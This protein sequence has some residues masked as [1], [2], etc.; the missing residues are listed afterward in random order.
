MRKKKKEIKKRPDRDKKG[1]FLK[2]AR[3]GP[4]RPK[5]QPGDIICK[6]GK[7]RS[8]DALIKDLLLAY[9]AMGGGDFIKKWAL[10][11][12]KNLTKFVE[13]LFRFAPQPEQAGSDIN[14]QVISAVPRQ[15]TDQRV[16]D[17]E[18]RLQESEAEL[19]IYKAQDLK[20]IEHEP[21][22]EDEKDPGIKK[23]TDDELDQ[24]I[25]KIQKEL[26]K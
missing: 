23:M 19:Q 9:E 12:H 10:H 18:R 8:V 7:R 5:S 25:E 26:R 14:I 13:I 22:R 16:R 11:S 21:I 2:G 1:R 20:V 4:G 6:D 24:E 15:A 17:L 3:A